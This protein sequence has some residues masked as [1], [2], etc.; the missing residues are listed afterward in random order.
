MRYAGAL[1]LVLAAVLA[2]SGCSDEPERRA[3][4]T[5]SPSTS[6]A[7]PS[8]DLIT[9]VEWDGRRI[10]VTCFGP[11]VAGVPTVLLEAGGDSP[12]DVWDPVVDALSRTVRTCDYDR[13]GLGAS[14]SA[15][16]PRR[17]SRDLVADLEKTLD[18]AG[19]E[20]P[21]LLV[22]H[23]MAV[24]PLSVY[25]AGHPRR[26]PASCWWIHVVLG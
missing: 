23:S 19:I 5:P 2:T 22:G 15:P 7:A 8:T 4:D 26:L 6:P 11:A 9:D 17:T 16:E 3:G 1:V 10:H 25:A 20:G 21:F 12:S 24:W 18:L 14:P 13:A